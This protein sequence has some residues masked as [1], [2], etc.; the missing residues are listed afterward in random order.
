LSQPFS[1]FTVLVGLVF[2]IAGVFSTV[3][4]FLR[5]PSG[6]LVEKVGS[7]T[8]RKADDF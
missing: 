7:T 5:R 3:V 6:T 1:I 2:A 4:L 8:D